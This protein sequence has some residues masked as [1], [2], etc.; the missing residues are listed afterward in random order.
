MGL[1]RA[2]SLEKVLLQR[3][4]ISQQQLQFSGPSNIWLKHC[5]KRR[6]AKLLGQMKAKLFCFGY[7]CY[8]QYTKRSSNTELK[9]YLNTVIQ[10]L[11]NMLIMQGMTCLWLLS[12]SRY[13]FYLCF[14]AFPKLSGIS[15]RKSINVIFHDPLLFIH[16]QLCLYC[17]SMVRAG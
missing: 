9:P 16:S 6:G 17:W 10:K 2:I 7:K 12:L 11:I 14:K 1:I 3:K 8:W 5:K 4:R 15:T 13:S